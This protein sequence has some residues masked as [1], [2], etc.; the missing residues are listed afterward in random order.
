VRTAICALTFVRAADY[1]FRGDR[2]IVRRNLVVGLAAATCAAACGP[3]FRAEVV[4]RAS[5]FGPG[6]AGVQNP[7]RASITFGASTDAEVLHYVVS[8]PRALE[9]AYQ[10]TCPSAE[11]HGTLGET[12]EHYRAR[13]LA[14]LERERKATAGLIGAAVG[15]ALPSVS[16]GAAVQAPGVEAGARADVQP[17][18]LA[19][20][21]ALQALP[22]AELPPGDTGA[23]VLRGQADLGANGGGTCTFAVWSELAEQDT[24]GVRV[25]VTLTQIVDVEARE[26]Q[27]R[28]ARDAQ[29]AELGRRQRAE[30]V[31]VL[32]R[33]G[34][35]PEL[36]ARRRAAEEEERRR[37]QAAADAA[38]ATADAERRRQQEAAD[39]E[40][41]RKQ[42]AADAE[43][44]RSEMEA[45]AARDAADA[46]RRRK[47]HAADAERQQREIALQAE[48]DAADAE[49]RRRDAEAQRARDAAEAARLR[50][51]MEAQAARDAADAERR[52][53]EAEQRAWAISL[54]GDVLLRLVGLGADP[55]YRRH[56][57]EARLR[58][59]WEEQRR[60]YA[61]KQAAEERLRLER[62]WAIDLRGRLLGGLLARGADP[63][64]RR[65]RDE[66]E[67]RAFEAEQ[68][69]LAEAK[70]EAAARVELEMRDALDLRVGLKLALRAEGAVD[71]P[72]PPPPIAESPPPA[73]YAGAVWIEG[74]QLWNGIAWIWQ[75]GHYE[76]PPAAG[77][78]WVPPT[79]I[80]VSGTVVVRPG[81]WV[82]VRVRTPQ[83]PSPR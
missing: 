73:P 12:F 18:A 64:F 63:D 31:A 2:V 35:D 30:I 14:D 83:L 77:T 82:S 15:A 62:A 48:R 66:A 11:R 27:A 32:L 8:T 39:A 17:G 38:R 76:R 51:E 58:A 68:R 47:Q 80:V 55:G 70:R 41:R 19:G 37:R 61:E 22:Q 44:Q 49:R 79:N 57:E 46:E 45:Q 5:V 28:A 4:G 52:R 24:A 69:R 29:Q 56:L 67:I 71:R 10:L 25:D 23:E 59:H 7:V 6:A 75:G 40:R 42:D 54:R 43:R 1:R 78:L 26:R 13:R 60:L 50:R 34:A 9:L 36:R 21:A 33:A 74:R 81:A 3:E 16:A 65:K 20:Q 53:R 72:P